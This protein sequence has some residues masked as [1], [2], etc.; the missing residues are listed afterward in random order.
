MQLKL[1]ALTLA[2]ATLFV[3][4]LA[5][6]QATKADKAEK[7]EKAAKPA[8][9]GSGI[10]VNGVM[11]PK[12]YLDAMNRER[13]AS[14]QPASPEFSRAAT[15]E[16]IN[17]AVIEQA[18]KKKGLDKD[19]ALAAQ[20]DMARQAVLIQAYLGSFVKENAIPEAQLKAQYEALLAQMG[21]K[22]Y[23]ARHILVDSEDEAKAIIASLKRGENFEKL[24][25]EKSKDTGSKDQGGDLDWGPAGRYVPEFGNALKALQKN[26]TTD[27]PVKTQF[28]FHVIRLDDSRAMKQQSFDE[29]K[30]PLRQRA[31]QEQVG[32]LVQ[33]LRAKAKVETN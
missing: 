3:L 17:R 11:I 27:T 31:Q 6:A 14:G 18:A 26:Q 7:T 8:V 25:K 16:L 15:E 19:P 32:R 13:E 10:T 23:K 24:A 12:A 30:E 21:D 33:D 28:G 1:K 9:A 22:E 2:V 29:V 20:M 4:P 5:N